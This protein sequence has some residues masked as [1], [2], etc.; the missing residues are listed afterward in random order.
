MHIPQI[1]GSV[2]GAQLGRSIATDKLQ[3]GFAVF[4]VG[5]GLFVIIKSVL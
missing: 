2:F 1:D 3:K 5:M 4:L